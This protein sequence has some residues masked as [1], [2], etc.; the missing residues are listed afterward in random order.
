VSTSYRSPTTST[1]S[2]SATIRW[3]RIF[4]GAGALR[5]WL[6]ELFSRFPRLRFEVEDIVVEG[7]PWSTRL[8]VR[9]VTTQDGQVVYRG[10]AFQRVVWG[11]LAEERILPDTQALA[12]VLAD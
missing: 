7:G 12:K 11:K 2:S 5:A 9:Y 3:R 10:T 4:N 8:A 6:R 1:S